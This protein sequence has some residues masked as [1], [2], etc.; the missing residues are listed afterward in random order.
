MEQ[1]CDG[2]L[3]VVLVV[4]GILCFF[5]L[6]RS[7]KGP[8]IADRIVAVNMIGTM[9][10]M[11]IAVLT[12]KLEEAFLAD[13]ALIYA[14]ISFLAVVVVAKVYMGVYREKTQAEKNKKE[15]K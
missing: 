7:V 2:F 3:T 5:C 14:M 10:M 6:V 4:L 15:E 9:T 13:V 12:V 11:G 1:F 8:R